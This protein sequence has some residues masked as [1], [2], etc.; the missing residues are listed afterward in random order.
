MKLLGRSQ[1]YTPDPE[2]VK[3]NNRANYEWLKENQPEKLVM[4]DIWIWTN[5]F[6]RT[7]DYPYDI[8]TAPKEQYI[9][10]YNF[11][12]SHWDF[13]DLNYIIAELQKRWYM[14]FF[15]NQENQSV[16]EVRH[17]HIIKF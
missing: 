5:L 3:D 11:N 16:P 1:P 10:C 6:I 15:N 2:S 14:V 12:C 4:E 9:I 8:P 13:D 7:Q 17:G